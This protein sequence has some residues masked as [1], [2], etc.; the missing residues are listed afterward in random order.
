MEVGRVLQRM[1]MGVLC[2]EVEEDA[3]S[4]QRANG[5]AAQIIDDMSRTVTA[6]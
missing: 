6:K 2:L 3:F 4:E 1:E 5:Y